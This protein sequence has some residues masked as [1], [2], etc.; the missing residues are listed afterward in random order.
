MPPRHMPPASEPSEPEQPKPE[1]EKPA[2]RAE[3]PAAADSTPAPSQPAP[4]PEGPIERAPQELLAPAIQRGV[5]GL[6]ELAARYPRDPAVLEPLA[7]A[8]SK[9]KGGELGSLEALDTLFAVAP[10]K[11]LDKQLATIVTKAA[12][13]PGDVAARALDL[14]AQR[15]GN[16]GADMLYDLW[17]TAP[18]LRVAARER[19][20]NPKV[21]ESFSPALAAAF[22]LRITDGCE[23]REKLLP[24]VAKVG[25]ERSI[26]ILQMLSSRTKKGCGYRKSRPCPPP[27]SKQAADF[28]RAASEIQK[29]LTAEAAQAK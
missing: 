18:K 2:P 8:H 9:Q 24:R 1:P 5:E 23:A 15:M 11:A 7:V 29:R 3:G 25:D 16:Q 14:M 6:K 17:V 10:H 13:G 27:C 4:M 22:D 20:D 26:A 21:R 19:L 28:K 12:L